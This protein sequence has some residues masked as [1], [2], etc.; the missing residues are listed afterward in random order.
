LLKKRNGPVHVKEKDSNM[1]NYLFLM[2]ALIFLMSSCQAQEKPVNKENKME[3]GVLIPP[4]FENKKLVKVE[5]SAEEWQAELTAQ[6][7]NILRE[8]GTERSF[9]GDLWDHKEKGTY[10]CAACGLP[11]FSSGTKFKSGTGWPSYYE[12]IKPEYVEEETDSSY[13]MKRV[14]VLCARCDGH[15][16]HVFEDGPKPTGLRYCIN[17]YSLDFVKEQP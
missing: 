13:G 14:E 8:A 11:L 3:E 16:G 15:L 2:A 5:K 6:E 12:P 4:S 17:S 1:K 7:Y 10:I 9:S